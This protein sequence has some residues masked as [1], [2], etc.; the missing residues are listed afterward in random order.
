MIGTGPHVIGP[1]LESE[2]RGAKA[3]LAE[4]APSQ[5]P[6]VELLPGS[7]ASLSALPAPPSEARRIHAIGGLS[8]RKSTCPRG[9]SAPAHQNKGIIGDAPLATSN[10]SLSSSP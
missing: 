8:K 9:R 3:A 5:E 6:S 2:Y 10:P 4:R 1:R 7:D